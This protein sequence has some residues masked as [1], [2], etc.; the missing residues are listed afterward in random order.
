MTSSTSCTQ[1]I[2]VPAIAALLGV[3]RPRV[4]QLRRV[5][6]F[7]QVACRHA[8][9]DW[10]AK[11]D[12]DRWITST[13]RRPAKPLHSQE[14]RFATL[15]LQETRAVS[16]DPNARTDADPSCNPSKDLYGDPDADYGTYVAAQESD[17][18]HAIGDAKDAI[19]RASRA[20]FELIELDAPQW[21]QTTEGDDAQTA[22]SD[23]GRAV[24]AAD[25]CASIAA[26]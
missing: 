9:R 15:D 12:I 18:L 6:G 1:I 14:S 22:L 7:P 3:S 19:Q 8:G 13:G 25:R 10:F 16:T 24:R 23:A 5:P 2:D 17:L 11:D 20:L 26:H 21:T 4:W